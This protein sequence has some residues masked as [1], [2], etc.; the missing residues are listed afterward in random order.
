MGEESATLA[1]ANHGKI[2]AWEI[3][4]VKDNLLVIR[5]NVAWGTQRVS[6]V[7]V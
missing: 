4:P 3:L 1:L 5:M 2:V 7:A 6:S